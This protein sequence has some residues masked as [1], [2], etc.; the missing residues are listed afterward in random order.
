[1][2]YLLFGMF[3][4][5]Y[6]KSHFMDSKLI[7]ADKTPKRKKGE[8]LDEKVQRH[9]KDKNDIITEEDLRDIVVG[10]ITPAQEEESEELAD[11]LSKKKKT[12]P[13]DILDENDSINPA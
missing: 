5:T 12:T 2:C 10:G 1:M 7:P 11:E 13:W 3:F 6:R 8:T 9:L 4:S